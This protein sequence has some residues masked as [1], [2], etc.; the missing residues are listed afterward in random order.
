M[1]V[2]RVSLNPGAGSILPTRTAFPSYLVAVGRLRHIGN[3][4]GGDAMKTVKI[5]EILDYYDGMQIFAA[6]DS[7]GSHYIGEMIDT[8]GD[9]DRYAVVSISSDRLADFRAGR[10]D[11]RTVL[12][13]IPG[14]EWYIMMPE[15]G[16]DDPQA[17]I[18]QSKSMA[19]ADVLPE[20]GFFLKSERPCNVEAIKRALE[21]GK[22]VALKGS[23]EWV[24]RNSGEWAL[25]TGNGLQSGKTYPGGPVLDGLQIGKHYRFKCAKVAELDLLWREQQVLY[26]HDIG[27]A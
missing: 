5:T 26:L 4:S 22:T 17:L 6:R 20:D 14:G 15:G 8:V 19:E 10:V 24:N 12:L 9:H 21:H 13:G 11:L 7:I 18:P 2:C 16:I 27:P 25:L 3:L 1:A 23:V